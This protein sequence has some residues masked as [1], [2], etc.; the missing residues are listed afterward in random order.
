[1]IASRAK[2][3]ESH[4]LGLAIV[5]TVAAMHAGKVFAAAAGN[6]R[7]PRQFPQ[8]HSNPGFANSMVRV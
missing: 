8:R 7:R 1:M 2:S 6:G 3:G 5:K 4:G